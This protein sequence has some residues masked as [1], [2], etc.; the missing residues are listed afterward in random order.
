VSAK[1]LTSP[2]LVEPGDV[3]SGRYQLERF[4]ASGGM[5][6]VF[7]GRHLELDQRVA[8]KVLRPE[9]LG[10]GSAVARFIRE[11]RTAARLQ[12]EH[13][14]R[15]FDV[16]TL[17]SGVPYMVMEYLT[18]VDLEQLRSDRGALPVEDAV[19]Y[20]LQTLEAIAEAHAHGIV[21]RDLKPANLFLASRPDGPP[22]IKVL[23]FGISK[24]YG[25]ERGLA[26]S[27]SQTTTVD[28][29]GSP[30]Y[31]SPEQV[32]DAKSIDGRSDIWS[33]GVTVYELL[34]GSDLFAGQTVGGTLANVLQREIPSLREKRPDIPLGLER[35][36][37]RCL[38]RDAARR[39]AD[40]AALARDLAPF[41]PLGA[42]LSVDRVSFVLGM[43]ASSV[44]PTSV[45]PVSSRA[46]V[47]A[48]TVRARTPF[49]RGFAI[50]LGALLCTGLLAL[51]AVWVRGAGGGRGGGAAAV[52]LI[53]ETPHQGA[54]AA[55]S[56]SA[57]QTLDI[58][59]PAAA[60]GA[61]AMAAVGE[62]APNPSGAAPVGT[63]KPAATTTPARVPPQVSTR[64]RALPSNRPMK[65]TLPLDVL[66]DRQ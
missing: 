47:V 23:D 35:V 53:T 62:P 13:I 52:T 48:T 17:P 55:S 25:P 32:R 30:A 57:P 21:H 16:G 26:A 40:A 59:T 45:S 61:S 12:S 20:M 54:A 65:G 43:G 27:G 10:H 1:P 14:A 38:E 5:G 41:A 31:M 24:T 58:V 34:T 9:V 29:V 49:P 60:L 42:Q 37:L 66:G 33:L 7:A 63:A 64:A 19:K 28:L 3:I 44:Q 50:G 6:I 4:I 8:V 22:R 46:Q 11:A 18:G 39:Y 36:I 56:T 15:V 51:A 2:I